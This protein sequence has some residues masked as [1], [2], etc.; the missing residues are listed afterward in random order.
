MEKIGNVIIRTME[1]LSGIATNG[2][3]HIRINK[4]I[5]EPE[6]FRHL[7]NHFSRG[8]IL[9]R[10]DLNVEPLETRLKCGC[11]HEE[12]V[13]DDHSGYKKCPSCGRFAEVQDNTYELVR[14]D[15]SKVGKRRSIRF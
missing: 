6:K 3:A 4:D 13:N 12:A 5:C 7:F 2:S 10:L 9:E 15:P 14:P 11:G 1:D 8:T